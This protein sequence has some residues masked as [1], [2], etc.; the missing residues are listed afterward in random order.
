M[1]RPRADRIDGIPPAVAV[2]QTNQ[3]RTSRLH[4]GH[5]DRD[6]RLPE[7]P[8]R[9]PR[10]APLPGVRGGGAARQPGEH[11]RPPAGRGGRRAGRSSGSGSGCPTVSPRRRSESTSRGRAT[12]GSRGAPGGTP[13]Y[14]S[15]RP[16][17]AAET[18][19]R[20][21]RDPPPE[22][23]AGSGGRGGARKRSEAPETDPAAGF[24]SERGA[25]SADAGREAGDDAAPGD[26]TMPGPQSGI[27][28]GREPRS[29][30]SILVIQDRLRLEGDGRTRLVEALRGR[31]RGR[32]R[33]GGG[34]RRDR[35]R[36]RA[37][38]SPRPWS[39]RAATSR[40]GTRSPTCSPSTPRSGPA[41]PAGDSGARWA[42]TTTS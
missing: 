22:A 40:T 23:E 28:C 13:D 7:A 30:S 5:H 36:R 11:R 17:A 35:P 8:L 18:E 19:S 34:G 37:G 16:A 12:P 42:S 3:V 9:A 20:P 21:A 26:E 32:P 29:R 33:A 10:A 1:D 14:A 24:R 41:I 31:A 27:G 4:G 2:D 15:G 39:V 25:G 6:Q 38:G